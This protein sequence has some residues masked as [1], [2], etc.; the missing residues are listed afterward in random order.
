M[1]ERLSEEGTLKVEGGT[2][3]S[4]SGKVGAQG[5][6]LRQVTRSASR[7]LGRPAWLGRGEGRTLC[8]NWISF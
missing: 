4:F 7:L 1:T 2:G 3:R 6:A 5:R 8:K